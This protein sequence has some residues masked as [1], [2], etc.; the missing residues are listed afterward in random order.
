MKFINS[1]LCYTHLHSCCCA[2]QVP[3][4]GSRKRDEKGKLGAYQWLTYAQARATCPSL[5]ATR[6][7]YPPPVAHI[8][9]G[10]CHLPCRM[11]SYRPKC[12]WLLQR[13]HLHQSRQ[14]S[15]THCI[16]RQACGRRRAFSPA[17]TGVVL[18]I[19][20]LPCH[21]ACRQVTCA[22]P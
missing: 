13:S 22:P 17:H 7:T 20:L 12:S 4:L 8:R 3:F 11:T 15:E 18:S 19:L 14:A 2:L 5:S 21:D 10:T 6:L 16:S 1:V 9:T